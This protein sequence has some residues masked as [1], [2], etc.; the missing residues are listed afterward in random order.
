M[1]IHTKNPK[2]VSIEF[3]I[4][5]NESRKTFFEVFELLMV[6]FVMMRSTMSKTVTPFFDEPVNEGLS[7][8][9]MRVE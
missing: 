2:L 3:G 8:S 4:L 9:Q 5:L 1:F 7:K 6:G